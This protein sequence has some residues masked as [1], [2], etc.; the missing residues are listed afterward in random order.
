MMTPD[1]WLRWEYAE[2]LACLKIMFAPFKCATD[3]RF[4]TNCKR[5]AVRRRGRK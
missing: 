3:H 2:K 5:G 1:D 4:Y